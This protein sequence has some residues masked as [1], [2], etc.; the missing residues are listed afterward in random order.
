MPDMVTID[1]ALDAFLRDQR[2]RLSD[3]TYRNYENVIRLLRDSLNSYAYSSLDARDA[4]RWQKAFDA[5][6][7]EAF[8]KLFGPEEIPPHL[9]E[10]LGYFMV[11]KV[12]AGQELLKAAG[13]VT[14]KLARWLEQQAYIES[15]AA[16]VAV[17]RARDSAREL[18]AADRLTDLLVEVA[19]KA[20]DIDVDDVGEEDWVEDQ[21]M[22]DQVEPGKIWFEGGIGPI[23]VP[24]RASEIAQPGWMV[25]IVAAR[26]N[27]SVASARGRLRLP[28]AA[29]PRTPGRCMKPEHDER[30]RRIADDYLDRPGGDYAELLRRGEVSSPDGVDPELWRAEIRAKARADKIRVITIRSGDRAIAVLPANGPEGS[31]VRGALRGDAARRGAPRRAAERARRLGHEIVRWVAHDQ[32]SI[33]MCPRCQARIY[34]RLDTVPPVVD[35]EALDE[36]ARADRAHRLSRNASGLSEAC[37]G[38]AGCRSGRSCRSPPV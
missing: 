35:G 16:E 7:E 25:F 3:R 4:K 18:P 2:A 14:G 22:I 28:V 32:E 33:A 30:F 21:L 36:P 15:D 13:T 6:D 29:E 12:S 5:G 1:Q 20:P 26:R 17:D 27:C 31:G 24:K 38:R 11:R 19:M 34:V 23:Q 10:F 9:G 37:S 8:C